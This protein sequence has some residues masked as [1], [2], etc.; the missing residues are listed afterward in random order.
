MRKSASEPFKMT[1][2]KALGYEEFHSKRFPTHWRKHPASG[3]WTEGWTSNSQTGWAA[4]RFTVSKEA[5]QT[6]VNRGSF[7]EQSPFIERKPMFR[8]SWI[9]Q[10]MRA[11]QWTPGPGSYRSEREF[12]GNESDKDALDT[13]NTI[14]ERAADF[15]FGRDVK[16]TT[17]QTSLMKKNHGLYPKQTPW[18]S[19]GPGAYYQT[20]QFGAASGGIR[21]QYLG[22][23]QAHAF[24]TIQHKEGK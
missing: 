23:T 22:G 21:E 5:L 9:Q 2:K 10:H 20:T 15:S 1:K 13:N 7:S 14:Q 16:E 18:F 24:N 8:D 12:I 11:T 3:S 6:S 4:P 17:G 19:P